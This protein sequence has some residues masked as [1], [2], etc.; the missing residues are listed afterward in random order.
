MECDRGFVVYI[1]WIFVSVSVSVSESVSNVPT[2]TA[3]IR[4]DWM[5][6]LHRKMPVNWQIRSDITVQNYTNCSG[7]NVISNSIFSKHS[8][9]IIQIMICLCN[10]NYVVLESNVVLLII[11]CLDFECRISTKI[12]A[13]YFVHTKVLSTRPKLRAIRKW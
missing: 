5:T 7:L 9:C 8:F 3:S 4:L 13:R 12:F 11:T 6:K 2:D 10:I 1:A